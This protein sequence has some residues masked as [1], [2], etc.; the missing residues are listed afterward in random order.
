MI[1]FRPLP[2]FCV[3]QYDFTSFFLPSVVFL[4]SV[5]FRGSVFLNI[6][7]GFLESVRRHY[8]FRPLPGFC[9]SQFV[10]IFGTHTVQP[11]FRPL[12]GFCVSQFYACELCN[13]NCMG[14]SVPFRGSVFLNM[15]RIRMLRCSFHVSVPF[16]GSVFLNHLVLADWEGNENQF[17][18]PSGVLC[19]SI[20]QIIS[21]KVLLS[22]RPLPGFCV[23]QYVF[24]YACQTVI[25]V[26]VP[27]RGS[28]FLNPVTISH[29]RH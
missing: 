8:S 27:F 9:V 29:S 18:S 23:S 25:N 14:V 11:R 4:V 26:S 20:N 10:R 2:G 12:P 3:S 5:P 13:Y 6:L 28:V 1:C 17:P 7:H 22:F 24:R 15:K 21:L 16:R 19:F